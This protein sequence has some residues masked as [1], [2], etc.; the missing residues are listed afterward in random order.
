[1]NNYRYPA[2]LT[3]CLV[4]LTSLQLCAQSQTPNGSVS[5]SGSKE[6]T[7]EPTK[8]RLTLVIQAEGRDAQAAIKALSQHKEKVKEG[9]KEMKAEAD[10][11]NFTGQKMS[12][13][14]AGMQ[15]AGNQ[16]Y[17]QVMRRAGMM[18]GMPA[19]AGADDEEESSEPPKIYTAK[20]NVQ[21]EWTLPTK[22]VEALA[23]LPESLKTQIAQRDL[24]GKKIKA[25]FDDDEKSAIED[26][27]RKVAQ[28]GYYSSS[29]APQEVQ[30]NFVGLVGEDKEKEALKEAY[31]S[32]LANAKDLAGATGM[33]LGKL[34]TLSRSDTFENQAQTQYEYDEYGN[35][36]RPM[37]VKR[38]KG[39]IV[40]TSPDSMTKT[41]VVNT[42]FAIE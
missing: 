8:L 28:M 33:K 17:Q 27:Q 12:T 14:I 6:V 30:I 32:A 18:N 5:A 38:K 10:S 42:T 40:S 35:A 21:A 34:L 20:C 36:V 19:A 41:V 26:I 13:A 37:A 24:Q 22:N 9:L 25:E 7:V 16:N 31:A 23:T 4:S 39:E 29:Q 11:I 3:L 2:L 1:M 15:A